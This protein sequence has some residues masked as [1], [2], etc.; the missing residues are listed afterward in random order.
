MI[1]H[2]GYGSTHF[3]AIAPHVNVC[4][5]KES[6]DFTDLHVLPLSP[7]MLTCVMGLGSVTPPSQNLPVFLYVNVW[8]G[9]ESHDFTDL[10]VLPLSHPML[11]YVM[12][13][14]KKRSHYLTNPVCL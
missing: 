3:A 12:G 6:H 9:K 5:G 13:G 11:T 7:P 4:H 2:E 1:N 14:S 8:H 10:H